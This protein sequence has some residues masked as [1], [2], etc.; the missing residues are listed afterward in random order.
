[1]KEREKAVY[2][3]WL[4]HFNGKVP[5]HWREW[6][7]PQ[8]DIEAA[9]KSRKVLDE[10]LIDAAISHPNSHITYGVA[11]T[12]KLDAL[13]LCVALSTMMPGG[14]WAHKDIRKAQVRRRN[15]VVI[16]EADNLRIRSLFGAETEP[17]K[18]FER[19]PSVRRITT[20]LG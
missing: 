20:M 16:G 19:F 12:Q 10:V 1:M 6:W 9:A 8:D 4:D 13:Q 15:R 2:L 7:G 11:M 14:P 3:A 18:G 5:A 17:L